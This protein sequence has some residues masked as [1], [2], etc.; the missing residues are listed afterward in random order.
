[1]AIKHSTLRHGDPALLLDLLD[2]ETLNEV[3]TRA[4]LLNILQRLDD[5][6]GK[7]SAIMGDNA[8]QAEY[9]LGRDPL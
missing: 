9:D 6:D 2:D 4:L 7:I 5:H 1:M 3:Q 8:A